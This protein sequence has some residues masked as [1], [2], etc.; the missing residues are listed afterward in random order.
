MEHQQIEALPP[1]P[2]II[3]SIKAGFDA[4]AN[5]V[6]V[7]ILPALLDTLLWIG[8][9]LSV[10]QL[11]QPLI[12]ELANYNGSSLISGFSI[13]DVQTIYTQFSEQFN[14]LS[15]LRT[16]PVGVS[17]LM[18]GRLLTQSPLGS[19]GILQVPTVFHLLGW[20]GLLVLVGWIGG[21]VY[22]QWVSSVT[23]AKEDD[24]VPAVNLPAI[25]NTI[26]LSVLWLMVLVVLGL[27]T[28]VIFSI[29]SMISLVLAQGAFLFLSLIG[30]WLIVPIFFSPH[31]IF[32]RK[33]DAFSSIMSSIR[34]ARFTLPTSSLF[35]LT[36]F[37]I[38]QGLNLLWNIPQDDSWM[39]FVGIGGHAFIT[40]ALLSA[41]FI[42]YQDMNAWLQ[43]V[44]ETLKTKPSSHQV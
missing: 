17:S 36:I 20:V 34:L 15:I 7:I 27:P 44:F 16:F 32:V 37:I 2:G 39:A 38:S 21:A 31:G 42:Y 25:F 40:T 18:S 9:R 10:K 19:R 30:L 35:V 8:P 5:H 26:I 11:M 24:T 13:Q 4:V 43:V 29:L 22:F 1:P 28:L 3:G 41:S 14:L 33:L 12:K 6:A 23:V